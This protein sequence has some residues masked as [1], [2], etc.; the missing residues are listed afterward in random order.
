[1]PDA[2]SMTPRLPEPKLLVDGESVG[3]A[4]GGTIPVTNPA[5]GETFFH[6]PAA[7]VSDVD[8]AVH[9]ARRAFESGPWSR[10]NPSH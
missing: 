5:T 10:M 4:E 3:P 8:K 1:M 6:A 7:G 2:R 9:A